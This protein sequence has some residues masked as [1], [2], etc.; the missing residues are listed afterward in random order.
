MWAI[1]RQLHSLIFIEGGRSIKVLCRYFFYFFTFYGLLFW[2]FTDDTSS[3][4]KQ[5]KYIENVVENHKTTAKRNQF[6]WQ[7]DWLPVF[8]V[9][10]CVCIKLYNMSLVEINSFAYSQ[11]YSLHRKKNLIF[12]V[13]LKTKKNQIKKTFAF[14]KRYWWQ[15]LHKNRFF[16]SRCYVD[17]FS[18]TRNEFESKTS[19]ANWCVKSFEGIYKSWSTTIKTLIKH[20]GKGCDLPFELV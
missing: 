15:H 7:K 1:D 19:S 6:G 17:V 18:T 13:E 20:K 16:V 10:F 11:K 2:V 9:F 12:G 4:S 3:K 8:C 14:E 5:S